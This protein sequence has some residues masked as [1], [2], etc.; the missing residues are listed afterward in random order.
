MLED[1]DHARDEARRPRR[2]RRV[3]LVVVTVTLAILVAFAVQNSQPVAVD[4]VFTDRRP[5]LIV[6]IAVAALLGFVVGLA[7]GRPNRRD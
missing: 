6:V 4:F 3:K 5:R 7:L 1:N 2:V